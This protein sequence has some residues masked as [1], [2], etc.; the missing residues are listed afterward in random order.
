MW[1]K[2][3]QFLELICTKM[4][5]LQ[6]VQENFE[7]LGICRNQPRFNAKSVMACLV[8]GVGITFST[9]F[10]I[11]DANN[12]QEYTNNLYITTALAAGLVCIIN[13]LLKMNHLFALTDDI[14]E[15]LDRSE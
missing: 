13:T 14:E 7:I 10:L 1:N 2:I 3:V 6:T 9:T 12:F 5:I 8:Y 15:T 11:C 4:K